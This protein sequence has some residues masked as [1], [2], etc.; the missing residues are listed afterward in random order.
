MIPFAE[1][2]ALANRHGLRLLAIDGLP[3]SGKTTLAGEIATL[4]G[5]QCLAVDDFFLRYGDFLSAVKELAGS[6]HCS[7]FPFD[8]ESMSISQELRSITLAD[9]PV[10]VEGTA[11]LHPDIASLFDL[12]FFVESDETSI[13]EAVLERDGNYF[14]KE[15]RDHWLPNAAL[16]M[17]TKP[18][19]RADYMVAG[20][21]AQR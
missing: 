4:T 5:F 13:L 1:A 14:E 9:G 3:C 2:C 7:Y 15:W 19:E 16:Y 8:W 6:G 12:R 21:G 20:R 11:S 10:L 18:R 17:K